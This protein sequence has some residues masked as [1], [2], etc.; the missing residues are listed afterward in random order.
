[1]GARV[2]L[3]PTSE[4]ASTNG[5]F[6]LGHAGRIPPAGADARASGAPRT[7]PTDRPE[8][9]VRLAFARSIPD[10][11]P[12]IATLQS[13]FHRHGRPPPPKTTPGRGPNRTPWM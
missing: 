9:L 12:G 4:L 5:P 2:E 6:V 7:A 11:R 1:A 13:G 3:P 10:G 8:G